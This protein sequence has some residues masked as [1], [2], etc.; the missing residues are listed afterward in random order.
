VKSRNPN[1]ARIILLTAYKQGQTD[2]SRA[3]LIELHIES[4]VAERLKEL[5]V[6][7]SALLHDAQQKLSKQDDSAPTESK[8][9]SR[10]VS[11]EVEELRKRLEARKQ[12]RDLP[13]E[14]ETARG[15]VVRCLREHDR[16]PL[17]CWEEVDR[18]KREVKKLEQGWVDKTAS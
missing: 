18:F 10:Q 11:K 4:R 16:R 3:R 1:F 13:A 14:V 6:K 5:H 8:I 17:D 7:E 9:S 15:E 12:V 2:A